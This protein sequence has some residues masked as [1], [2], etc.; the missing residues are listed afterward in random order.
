MLAQSETPLSRTEGFPAGHLFRP[1]Q[2]P[3]AAVPPAAAVGAE[4]TAA[5][6][7]ESYT[8]HGTHTCA[9]KALRTG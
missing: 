9:H 8:P 6:A 3:P 7:A 1:V 2:P 4:A 5:A